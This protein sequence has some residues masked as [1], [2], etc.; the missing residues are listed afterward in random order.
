MERNDSEARREEWLF[1]GPSI[2]SSGRGIGIFLPGAFRSKSRE[3]FPVFPRTQPW[4]TRGNSGEIRSE[5]FRDFADV[6]F[7]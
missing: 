6:L 1:L 2:R 7:R 4:N 3:I 5:Q